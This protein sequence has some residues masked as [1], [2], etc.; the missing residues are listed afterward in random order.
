MSPR[1][2][3]QRPSSAGERVVGAGE[4]LGAAGAEGEGAADQVELD[5]GAVDRG[6]GVEGREGGAALVEVDRAAVVGVDHRE[7]PELVALVDVG[8]AGRGE[9]EQELADGGAL[10]ALARSG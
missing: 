5:V 6:A 4:G 7:A 2:K 3:A 1:V 10:A 8:D 9:F